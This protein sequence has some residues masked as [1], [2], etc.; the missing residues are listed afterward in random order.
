MVESFWLCVLLAQKGN[1]F[2]MLFPLLSKSFQPSTLEAAGDRVCCADILNLNQWRSNSRN[3]DLDLGSC[4]GHT[5][6]REV[7]A[8]D[9]EVLVQ[10]YLVNVAGG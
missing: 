9:V 7:S 1:S 2:S 10:R 5:I 4:S 8:D 6:V 3:K